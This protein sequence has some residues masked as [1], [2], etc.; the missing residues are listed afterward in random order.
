MDIERLKNYADLIQSIRNFPSELEQILDS[1]VDLVDAGLVMTIAQAAEMLEHRGDL[2]GAK[3]LIKVA[4]KIGD[5]LHLLSSTS[6]LNPLPTL[7]S[8]LTFFVQVFQV[9]EQNNSNS[10]VIYTLLKANLYFL[11]DYFAPLWKNWVIAMISDA[12]SEETHGIATIVNNFSVLINKFPLGNRSI[13]LEIAI[14]GYEVC[15]TVYTRNNFSEEWANVHNNLGSAYCERIRGKRSDNLEIA[16][17]YLLAALEVRTREVAPEKWAETQNNLGLA[18]SHRIKEERAEN[19]EKALR[20]LKAALTIRTQNDFPQEWAHTQCNL[21]CVY[22]EFIRGKKTDNQEKAISCYL[23]TLKVFTNTD[24]PKYWADTQNNL[25]NV[26]IERIQGNKIEN[27]AAAIDY[28]SAALKV[29]TYEDFPERWAALHNNLANA[30]LHYIG[31]NR[32]ENLEKA[33]HSCQAALQVYIHEDFPKQWALLQNNLGNVFLYRRKGNR[34]EN[35]EA[36]IQCYLAALKVRT[37][38][39]FILD[40]VATQF[41]LGLAY[42]AAQQ[43]YQS[44][45]AFEKAI[46]TIES[47]RVEIFAGS[48]REED[49]K[50][51]A[52][53]WNKLYQEIVQVCLELAKDDRVYYSQAID[54]VERSKARNLVEL[55]ANKDIYPKLELYCHTELYQ[56]HCH[57]LEQLRRQIPARQRELEILILESEEKNRDEI[58][59]RR[60]ELTQLQQQ[61]D[62][63]LAEI[64]QIDSNFTFTQKVQ[65]IPF[66]DI[67]SLTDETTAIVEWYITGSQILTFIITRHHPHPIVISSSSEDMTVL[68]NWDREYRDSYQKQNIQWINNLADRLQNIAEILNIDEILSRI[69]DCFSQSGA[70]CNRLI[71]IPHRY[72]H[73][74]PLHALPLGDGKLLFERFSQGVGYAPS[75]KLLKQAKDQEQHRPDFTRLFA[76]QNPTRQPA[77]PLLGSQLEIDKI[78]QHFDPQQS[79]LLKEAEATEVNLYQRMEQMRYSHCIHFSCHGKFYPESPLKS[80]LLLADPEG[81]LGEEANLTLGEVFEKLYLNQ[82]R[83]VTFSACESGMTDPNSISDEYIGLPSGFLYAGSLSVVSTLWSVD[84]IATTL[85]MVKFYHN[86]KRLPQ[87]KT[88]DV[89]IALNKA[90]KW[91]KTLTHKKWARIQSYPQFQNLVEEAFENSPKRDRNKFKDSLSESLSLNRQPLPFANPYYWSAFVAIGI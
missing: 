52:E 25:G 66:S 85:L 45:K 42:Q 5:K 80:A 76:I 60:Q 89:A 8:L 67:Q 65:P 40:Y 21:G 44:Y 41:N 48:G 55:L 69:D 12:S 73:L 11:G 27:L 2:E 88:G 43:L 22:E 31:E 4:H 74:F 64:N 87:I 75:C 77:R 91:L 56:T 18:Y 83:L 39:A 47:M 84:P 57:R 1:K 59:Q 13:N 63:L 68:E 37:R 30:Y 58:E 61:R 62:E 46:D 10:E 79:F 86:L 26:Y 36:A 15:S 70:K 28:Y 51:L 23:N 49:K 9:T 33:I 38:D 14:A 82:C 24:F 19:L 35:L 6:V 78:R 53:D 3:L 20:C 16:I 32:T 7:S 50:K 71:L 81:K 29:H 90:Q 72:L 17:C 34:N 54:Y